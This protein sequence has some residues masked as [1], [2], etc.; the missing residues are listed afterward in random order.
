MRQYTFDRANPKVQ[1]VDFLKSVVLM[2]FGL[3][4]C[5]FILHNMIPIIGSLL[6]KN[7]LEIMYHCNDQSIQE[8]RVLI[9]VSKLRR[10][11][12]KLVLCFPSGP[13]V[14]TGTAG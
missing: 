6:P 9:L 2:I 10:R 4:R 14:F 13:E 8:C 12:G 3:R 11:T 1:S 7:L 5:Y